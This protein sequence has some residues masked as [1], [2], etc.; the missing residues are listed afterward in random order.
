MVMT[1][2]DNH[3]GSGQLKVR[4]LARTVCQPHGEVDAGDVV[5]VDFQEW[6][7]LRNN[8]KAVLHVEKPAA[9]A[10]VVAD[11]GADGLSE[12]EFQT[13]LNGKTKAQLVALAKSEFGK[14]LNESAKKEDLIAA[15]VE[16][17]KG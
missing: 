14:S 5:S 13:A 2:Y 8:G 12:E 6:L 7:A 9:A 17:A 4:I 16:A 3:M 1:T 15:I 11:A 10:V